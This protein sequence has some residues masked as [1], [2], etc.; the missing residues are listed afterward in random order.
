MLIQIWLSSFLKTQFSG[1]SLAVAGLFSFCF[2]ASSCDL[3]SKSI[4]TKTVVQVKSAEAEQSLSLQGFSKLLARQLK[5]LDPLSAKDPAIIKKFK[6]QIVSN[7]I[8]DSLIELWFIESKG[9]VDAAHIEQQS[10]A[11]VKK[12]PTDSAFRAALAE[13]DL[14]FD[15]W[16][17][18]L[19]KA[20]KR[21]LLFTDLQKKI[22]QPTEQDIQNYYESNKAKFFQKES[23]LAKSILIADEAQADVI[24]KLYLKTSIEQLIQDYSI[25]VPRPKDGIYSWIERD[26]AQ[27]LDILF[28]NKKNVLIGPIQMDEGFRLFK[29]VQRKPARQRASKEVLPQIKNEIL[30]LRETAR[31]SAWLDTQIKRY[32]IYKNTVAIDAISVETRED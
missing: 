20:Y 29:V 3:F 22:E 19:R 15:E 24:K 2:F 13:E 8:V 6:D 18:G 9:A 26:S 28:E 21:Q 7:F 23:V 27:S 17:S 11:M 25:E 4:L 1:K 12:Y 30:S 5:F 31:F 16:V 10:L 32:T 14:S